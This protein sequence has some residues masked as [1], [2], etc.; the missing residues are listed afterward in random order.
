MLLNDRKRRWQFLPAEDTDADA[1]N[2]IVPDG[3]VLRSDGTITVPSGHR[4]QVP[5]MLMDNTP[6]DPA[7]PAAARAAKKEQERALLEAQA[8]LIEMER[9]ARDPSTARGAAMAR[10]AAA[11]IKAGRDG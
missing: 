1:G 6:T 7:D 8:M 11:W 2:R 9:R 4:V 3:A 10:Q 5:L